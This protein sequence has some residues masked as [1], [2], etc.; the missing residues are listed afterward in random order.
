M[1]LYER[2]RYPI[3]ELNLIFK[4]PY[5]ID[6]DALIKSA[7]EIDPLPATA[8]RLVGLTSND[9]WTWKQIVEVIK[10]DPIMVTRLLRLAN[11]A[12]YYNSNGP[13]VSIGNAV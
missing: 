11:S 3:L 9:A 2:N 7:N 12:A 13:I 8:A 6:L 5:M 4:L 10:L 1:S